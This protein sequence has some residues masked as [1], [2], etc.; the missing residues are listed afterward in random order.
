MSAILG[1]EKKLKQKGFSYPFTADATTGLI[2]IGV[3]IS[4]ARGGVAI[5]PMTLFS[6]LLATGSFSA[7]YQLFTSGKILD[8]N[9][10]ALKEVM[11][12]RR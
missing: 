9:P 1:K 4:I 8:F 10:L 2:G 6:F 12:G 5:V 11:R 3:A 7:G